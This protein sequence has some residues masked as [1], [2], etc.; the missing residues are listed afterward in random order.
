MER[1]LRLEYRSDDV[2][3]FNRSFWRVVP[4]WRVKV[5]VDMIGHENYG[6]SEASDLL[7]KAVN[8]APSSFDSPRKN[9]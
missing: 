5:G 7:P 6:I 3:D 4:R 9:G 1:F 8:K 2:P